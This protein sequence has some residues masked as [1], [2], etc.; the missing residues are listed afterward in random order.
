MIEIKKYPDGSLRE[1]S[2]EELQKMIEN[3]RRDLGLS[4]LI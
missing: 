3:I 4:F 2:I 1:K